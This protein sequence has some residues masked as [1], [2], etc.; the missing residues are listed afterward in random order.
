MYAVKKDGRCLLKYVEAA[1]DHLV[2]R[3]H[4]HGFPVQIMPVS[5]GQTPSDYLVG[6]I[7]YVGIGT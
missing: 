2:L 6:R 1:G 3:P 7:C 4:N 5:A